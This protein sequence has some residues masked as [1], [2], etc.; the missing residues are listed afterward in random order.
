M[1][2]ADKRKTEPLGTI[3]VGVS[4]GIAAYKIGYAVRAFVKAGYDVHVLPTQESLNFVGASTWAEL[5]GNHV[6]TSVFDDNGPGH[7]ELARRCDL[8]VVAPATA[9][10]IASLRLGIGNDMLTTTA[11]ATSAPMVVFPA[12]HTQMWLSP[13]TQ[14]NI[15]TLRARGVN[16]VAPVE[17]DLS[18][19]D[20]GMGRLPEPEVI[21]ELALEILRKTQR[22][23]DSDLP[24]TGRHILITAGGNQEPIDPVR[25]IGNRSSGTQG[26]ALTQ[27]ALDLGASVTLIHGA[28]S[29]PLPESTGRL[30]VVAALTSAQMYDAVLERLEETDALIMAAA[31][32]DFS[33]EDV[34]DSK[35]KKEDDTEELVLRL[36]RTKDILRSVSTSHNRPTVLVG[37]GAETG[38]DEEVLRLGRKKALAKGA[39]LLAVN[40]VGHGAGFGPVENTLTLFDSAGQVVGKA[41]GT[42]SKLARD[43]MDRVT[44]LF[45]E[46]T[47]N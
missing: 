15:A 5:T 3:L 43:L 4:A 30:N 22:E 19:G 7:I 39:D 21:A 44:Q 34:R 27:A 28:M 35:I 23:A 1:S 9:N 37:F 26:L 38:A 8:F 24:L 14:D 10:T 36:N 17:G 31:V 12:M 46:K 40:L 6:T 2:L 29:A 25:Y 16:V 20:K 18:S 11:L 42:K 33:P 41:N 45:R 47:L 13:A 32:A